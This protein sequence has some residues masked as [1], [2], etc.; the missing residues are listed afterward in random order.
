[1]APISNQSPDPG[2]D[3]S[4]C[5]LYT[6][7]VLRRVNIVKNL[8]GYLMIGAVKL[9]GLVS[10]S[11]AQK[12]GR[13]LGKRLASKRTRSRE[14]ARV[15]LNLCY[16]DKSEDFRE[17]LLYDTLLQN[18]MTGG[19]MGPMWGYS[20]D[21]LKSLIG[22][23]H[24]I[25]L[26]EKALK[27]ERGIL[28]MSPHL[29]N[30]E[31]IN[32]WLAGLSPITIMYRPAKAKN[33]SDWM[34]SRREAVGC[35][36]V[37]TTRDGVKTLFETLKAGKMVGFL[38]DQE[39]KRERG[40]FA[41]FMGVDTLTPSLPHQMIQ[42]TGCQVLYVFGRR[43]PDA[44]GFD[45]HISEALPEQFDQDPV[46]SATAMNKAIENC[47]AICP[48]QYQWTYKRFKRRPDDAAN[49]YKLAKVP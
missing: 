35:D 39:P 15:N 37:P 6:L 9:M 32:A 22:T 30:W 45:I 49:P 4:R 46:V 31:I 41:P 8:I 16:P 19:E 28:L 21:K 36:L 26:L 27:D 29:G 40:V 11:R 5:R 18:G 12:V 42:E 34:V 7:R 3:Q 38:P 17:A 24:N 23:V 47:V 44:A 43:L 33:F 20:I 48:D 10:F 25:E 14:V 2:S 13:Y 1:M